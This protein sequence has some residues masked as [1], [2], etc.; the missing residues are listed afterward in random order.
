MNPEL[1]PDTGL[2]KKEA[3]N[4]LRD[5]MG[6]ENFSIHGEADVCEATTDAE[7]DAGIKDIKVWA[8]E[9]LYLNGMDPDSGSL[10]PQTI[11]KSN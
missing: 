2:H 6:G 9:I 5:G 3:I 10:V 7:E 8:A 1:E 4:H 11:K